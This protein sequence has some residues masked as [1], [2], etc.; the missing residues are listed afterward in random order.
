MESYDPADLPVLS[1]LAREFAVFDHWFCSVPSETI[2]NRNFW[3]AGTSWGHVI[4][5]GPK[6]DPGDQDNQPN[7]DA[8]LEDTAGETLFNQ[9]AMSGISWKIYSDNKVPVSATTSVPLPVTPLLHLLSF[10]PLYEYDRPDLFNTLEGFKADCANG[11]LPAYSFIEP[12][13]FNPHNDMHPSTPREQ[14][15][16]SQKI[17]P[18]WLGEILVMEIYL[19]IF[20]SKQLRDNTLLVITFDEHG[21]C[22]DHVWP[23]GYYGGRKVEPAKIATPPDLDGYTKFDGFGFDRLGLRVPMIMVS[24][25]IKANTIINTPMSHTS[26]LKTMHEKWNLNSLSTREDASPSFN[27][28]GLFWPSLQRERMPDMPSLAAP[29]IPPNTDYSK[30]ALPAFA[31]ANISLIRD[32]WHK[33]RN[34]PRPATQLQT[35]EDAAA[36]LHDAIPKAKLML[37]RPDAL[38]GQINDEDGVLLLRAIAVELQK[39]RLR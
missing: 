3:H 6:D 31:K 28:P 25:H 30:T 7:T 16:G 37:G 17:S 14:I 5:P 2:C 23:P 9:L 4:N 21:G 11:W 27:V 39:Q 33:A 20:G 38:T 1:F 18:V 22:Y 29:S 36:F 13:F 15:D 19:A 8:W 12:N 26:F 35:H 34:E 32:L 10:F 24:P